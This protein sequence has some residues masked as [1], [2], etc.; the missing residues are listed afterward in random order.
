MKFIRLYEEF[1]TSGT[2]KDDIRDILIDLEDDGFEVRISD[3]GM[4]TIRKS[5]P[6][7]DGIR[8]IPF[9]V[10]SAI[11]DS[12]LRLIR[13]CDMNKLYLISFKFSIAFGGNPMQICQDDSA[14][15]ITEKG[16]F[17]SNGKIVDYDINSIRIEI[18]NKWYK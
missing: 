1:D 15:N 9:K 10:D 5:K 14:S 4:I 6:F 16:I 12:I 18:S 17:G 3:F 13:Y 11:I 8:L 2:I 7:L